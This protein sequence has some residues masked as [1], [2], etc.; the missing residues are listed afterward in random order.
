MI[1][2]S[3]QGTRR[4]G[5]GRHPAG[6]PVIIV[7][8]GLEPG[9]ISRMIAGDPVRVHLADLGFKG[10]VGSV[11]IVIFTGPSREAMEKSLQSMIGPDTVIHREK[12]TDRD[13]PKP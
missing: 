12:E 9:N 8:L 13:H 7:G 11:D 4:K 5:T 6:E 10:A 1:K 2:F 3:A